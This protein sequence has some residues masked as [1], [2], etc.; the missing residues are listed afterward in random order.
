MSPTSTSRN[1]LSAIRPIISRRAVPA[2][3]TRPLSQLTMGFEENQ[4]WKEWRF[5]QLLGGDSPH[6]T[7]FDLKVYTPINKSEIWNIDYS[8]TPK[9]TPTTPPLSASPL[10]RPVPTTLPPHPRVTIRRLPG[11]STDSKYLKSQ[12]ARGS[13][14]SQRAAFSTT[15]QYISLETVK[16]LDKGGRVDS[17]TARVQNSV[18]E[19]VVAQDGNVEKQSGKSKENNQAD[20][21][22]LPIP[23]SLPDFLG[24]GGL[25]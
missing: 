5:K 10:P 3:G 1:A 18:R 20:D 11:I 14:T 12:T 13:S 25:F 8:D 24:G 21:K 17:Q 15:S 22:T 7:I 4:K 9:Q 2:T 6:D 19:R 23:R 16:S